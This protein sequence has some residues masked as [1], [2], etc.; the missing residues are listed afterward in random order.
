MMKKRGKEIDTI[1]YE[2]KTAGG[3]ALHRLPQ[4]RGHLSRRTRGEDERDNGS[5][6][7]TL[8]RS[9]HHLAE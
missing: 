3:T 7:L 9:H 8:N 1:D 6:F 5:I 4:P 2:A